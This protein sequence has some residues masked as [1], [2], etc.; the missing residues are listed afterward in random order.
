[1]VMN[2]SFIKPVRLEIGKDYI[3]M[4]SRS[5][6][7]GSNIA[8]AKGRGEVDPPCK[9]DYCCSLSHPI[10]VVRLIDCSYFNIYPLCWRYPPL[11][12]SRSYKSAA[13]A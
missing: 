10:N 11:R 8:G 2:T 13:A 1:M 3:A 7:S 4:G 6:G 12:S 5:I 9:D